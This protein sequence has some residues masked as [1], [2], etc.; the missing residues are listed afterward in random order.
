MFQCF[1]VWPFNKL[2]AFCQPSFTVIK[3]RWFQ[4]TVPYNFLGGEWAIIV[5]CQKRWKFH[6]MWIFLFSTLACSSQNL[7]QHEENLYGDYIRLEAKEVSMVYI[8][9]NSGILLDIPGANK[10]RNRYYSITTLGELKRNVI[11][12][13]CSNAV[14]NYNRLVDK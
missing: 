6:L 10:I 1:H 4:S 14:I 5:F 13:I 3:C 9:Q 2:N 8:Y 7:R 12:D 11:P